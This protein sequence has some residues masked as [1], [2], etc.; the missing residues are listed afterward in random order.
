MNIGKGLLINLLSKSVF[1]NTEKAEKFGHIYKAKKVNEF[2]II[3]GDTLIT[4][5]ILEIVSEGNWYDPLQEN[6]SNWS[7]TFICH[8]P[9]EGLIEGAYY[10]A[11]EVCTSTDWETGYCDDTEVYIERVL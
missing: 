11:K 3:D 4:G 9:N 2:G 10:E 7:D 8:L 6:I 5:L 1:N